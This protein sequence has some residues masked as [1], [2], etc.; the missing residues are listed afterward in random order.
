[1]ISLL[2]LF[3]N[4]RKKKKQTKTNKQTKNKPKQTQTQIA[5]TRDLVRSPKWMADEESD[6]CGVCGSPF[7]LLLR[8]HHCRSCGKIFCGDCTTQE[9]FFT[10]SQKPERVCNQ[11]I[12]F[13][14]FVLFFFFKKKTQTLIFTIST[15]Q[16]VSLNISRLVVD[17]RKKEKKRMKMKKNQNR[18]LNQNLPNLHLKNK[19]NNN[20]NNNNNHN[21][22]RN[23]EITIKK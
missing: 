5:T 14:P 21:H 19:H 13:F 2:L 11:V 20:N 6:S 7:T 8:R 3:L 15:K 10:D 12:F 4:V 1:V 23:Q 22:K 9:L 16:S 17:K 18:N